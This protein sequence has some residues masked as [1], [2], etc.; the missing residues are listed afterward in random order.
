MLKFVPFLHR[1]YLHRQYLSH[2]P[3]SHSCL[4]CPLT[5]LYLGLIPC[6]SFVWQSESTCQASL[7]SPPT[8]NKKQ[9][10]ISCL[11]LPKLACLGVPLIYSPCPTLLQ[12][13]LLNSF[14]QIPPR[15]FL[16]ALP[17]PGILFPQMYTSSVSSHPYYSMTCGLASLIQTPPYTFLAL[18][19][20][21]YLVLSV[22]YAIVRFLQ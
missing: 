7:V 9:C 2:H 6:V 17:L 14:T 15:D 13:G 4:Q 8:L 18:H 12:Y 11:V 1:Q 5:V 20:L 21:K 16:L 22:L 10:L 3:F 19:D